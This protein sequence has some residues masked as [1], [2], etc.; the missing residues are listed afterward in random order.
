MVTK[1][2]PSESIFTYIQSILS[3]YELPAVFE[4]LSN[5][6]SREAW[7]RLLNC[8]VHDMVEA[9]WKAD[10]ESKSFTKYLNPLVLNVGSIYG[11][12]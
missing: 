5:P 6:P 12:L 7:K 9:A 2:S 4:L 8:K 11:P 1:D 3:H 10:V